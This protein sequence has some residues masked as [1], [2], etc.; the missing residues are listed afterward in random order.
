MECVRR[1][2]ITAGSDWRDIGCGTGAVTRAVLDVAGPRRVVGVEP[3]DGYVRYARQHVTD[4][5]AQFVRGDAM[6]LPF[7]DGRASVA[8]SGLV[9]NFVPAP[10][11][12]VAEM[13]RIVRP[14]GTVAAY[15]WDYTQGGMELIR[16]FWEAAVS[17]DEGS[18]KLDE[19]LRFPLCAPGPLGELL[20]SAG[21]ADVEVDEIDIPTRFRDFDDY[22]AP[23][24]GGQGPAPSYLASL[25]QKGQN[26]LRERLR[27]GV[28]TE[29]DGSIALTARAWNGRGRRP[30]AEARP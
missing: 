6:R 15:V 12:T 30:T 18:R 22:W 28:P 11:Q 3:S 29:A 5:R 27:A 9:L 19:A 1:L 13:A 26:A 10:G 17:L 25:S 4:S 20:R 14:G 16:Y 23:F 8:V 24:L 21:L 7:P 2:D